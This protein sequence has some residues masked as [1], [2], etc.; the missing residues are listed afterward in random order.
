MLIVARNSHVSPF[1][2][3]IPLSSIGTLILTLASVTRSGNG[4]HG[5]GLSSNANTINRRKGGHRLASEPL[6]VGRR[7]EPRS[8]TAHRLLTHHCPHYGPWTFTTLALQ[9]IHG[10]VFLAPISQDPAVRCVGSWGWD[11]V[12]STV[13]R[14]LEVGIICARSVVPTS[15]VRDGLNLTQRIHACCQEH[16]GEGTPAHLLIVASQFLSSGICGGES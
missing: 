5:P 1:G 12:L 2:P 3:L 11:E 14:D 7:S 4:G 9:P 16:S 6:H 8:T 10:C 15:F 13:F